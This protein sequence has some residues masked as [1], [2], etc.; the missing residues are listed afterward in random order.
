MRVIM[1]TVVLLLGVSSN[2]RNSQS[3]SG[4]TT[5][6]DVN[7]TPVFCEGSYAHSTGCGTHS[8]S[9]DSVGIKTKK[10]SQNQGSKNCNQFVDDLNVACR[11]EA[12]VDV[13]SSFACNKQMPVVPLW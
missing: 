3:V 2:N 8:V 7:P 13:L 12:S 1:F 6:C 11:A 10:S 4:G 9:G 5:P